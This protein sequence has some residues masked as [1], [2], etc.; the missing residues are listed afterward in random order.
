M[1]STVIVLLSVAM[2]TGFSLAYLLRPD[3]R[4]QVEEPKHCFQQQLQRYDSGSRNSAS[5]H[6]GTP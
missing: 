4:Q 1:I 5:D 3:W 2:A 6:E